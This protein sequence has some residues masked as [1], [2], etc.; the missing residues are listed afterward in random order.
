LK[1]GKPTPKI[2]ISL[3]EAVPVIRKL[4]GYLNRKSAPPPGII[5][6]IRGIETLNENSGRLFIIC[7]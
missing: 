5:V 7:G 4:G 3:D 1:K 6:L 2:P